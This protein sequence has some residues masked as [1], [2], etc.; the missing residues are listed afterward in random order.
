[1][2]CHELARGVYQ[3]LVLTLRVA[4]V[5]FRRIFDS[6]LDRVKL[7]GVGIPGDIEILQSIGTNKEQVGVRVFGL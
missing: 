6:L 7:P 1:M 2:H 5:L 3:A 4:H